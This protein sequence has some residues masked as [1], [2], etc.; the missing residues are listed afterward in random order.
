[1]KKSVVYRV[2]LENESSESLIQDQLKEF[3]RHG[4]FLKYRFDWSTYC[5]EG[6]GLYLESTD[7]EE[8]SPD[9]TSFKREKYLK[10]YM[11]IRQIYPIR[12]ILKGVFTERFDMLENTISERLNDCWELVSISAA[13]GLMIHSGKN[14]GSDDMVVLGV[15][16]V[17][18]KRIIL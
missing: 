5:Q 1:M 7:N 15:E 17:F 3:S 9:K 12:S 18:K 14:S 6:I 8:T 4:F 13:K 16:V 2:A 11:I 10:E